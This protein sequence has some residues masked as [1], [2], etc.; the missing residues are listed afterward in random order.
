MAQQAS[1]KL[2]GQRLEACAQFSKSSM[3]VSISPDSPLFSF[4]CFDILGCL[5]RNL[6][7]KQ[8][9]Q[10]KNNRTNFLPFTF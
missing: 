7:C 4:I 8:A 5:H 1:P 6:K 3:E 9:N 2:R 10:D